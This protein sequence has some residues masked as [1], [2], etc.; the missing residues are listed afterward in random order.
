VVP[1]NILFVQE[2]DKV[3]TDGVVQDLPPPM[4]K[5]LKEFVHMITWLDLGIGGVFF[6]I[7]FAICNPFRTNLIFATVFSQPMYR[8]SCCPR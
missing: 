7:G 8:W 6:L 4:Q 2:G 1:G 3:S 5:E